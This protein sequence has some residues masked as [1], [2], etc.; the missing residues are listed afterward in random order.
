MYI[1]W[2]ATCVHG[3]MYVS[4][5]FVL[6][7]TVLNPCLIKPTTFKLIELSGI[8]VAVIAMENDK[9]YAKNGNVPSASCGVI[10]C[11]ATGDAIARRSTPIIY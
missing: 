11:R 8:L 4:T 9:K 5:C 3:C 7:V 10:V 2:V 1:C 6:S